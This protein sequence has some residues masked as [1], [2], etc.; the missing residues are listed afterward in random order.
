MTLLQIISM[1]KRATRFA[2]KPSDSYGGYELFLERRDGVC[3]LGIYTSTLVC[4]VAQSCKGHNTETYTLRGVEKVATRKGEK[5]LLDCS[6]TLDAAFTVVKNHK[7]TTLGSLIE[8]AHLSGCAYPT[9][10]PTEV[11][12]TG[13]EFSDDQSLLYTLNAF[14]AFRTTDRE[15]LDQVALVDGW[16]SFTNGHFLLQSSTNVTTSIPPDLACFTHA[17]I[18]SLVL[19]GDPITHFSTG[20]Y[21]VR[22]V[23]CADISHGDWRF[24]CAA[25]TA[26]RPPPIETLHPKYAESENTTLIDTG[27]RS[28]FVTSGASLSDYLYLL[29]KPGRHLYDMLFEGLT[30]TQRKVKTEITI[31]F[32][33]SHMSDAW[34]LYASF[35][36]KDNEKWSIKKP[37]SMEDW[38][39]VNELSND[40]ILKLAT[41]ID[42]ARPAVPY[43]QIDKAGNPIPIYYAVKLEYLALALMDV[44]V[45]HVKLHHEPEGYAL[46]LSFEGYEGF[47]GQV[48]GYKK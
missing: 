8:M 24:M 7:L 10:P 41:D 26:V 22:D 18:S 43:K 12:L 15:S 33:Y 19:K 37:Y 2:P 44:K 32:E 6:G 1:F 13:F 25:P 42:W 20:K 23:V 4:T 31:N 34:C 14:S 5:V 36:V 29:Q 45:Q 46:L 27:I 30:P 28:D 39:R 17:V 48:M 3:K 47:R 11:A 40:T 9:A 21:G 35:K 16:L 38:T